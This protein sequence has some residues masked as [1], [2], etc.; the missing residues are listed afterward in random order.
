MVATASGSELDYFPCNNEGSGGDYVIHCPRVDLPRTK[1]ADILDAFRRNSGNGDITSLFIYNVK[2]MTDEIM[3]QILDIVSPSIDKMKILGMVRDQLTRVPAAVQN[4]TSLTHFSMSLRPDLT[5]LPAGSL[6]FP[7]KIE[8]IIFLSGH[9]VT[10]E[11]GAFQGITIQ[12]IIYYLLLL[13]LHI[14]M[15]L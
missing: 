15:L 12:L 2:D 13:L 1:A 7:W 8:S 3:E 5:V 14:I 10:I 9:L 6:V 11:P 4:F